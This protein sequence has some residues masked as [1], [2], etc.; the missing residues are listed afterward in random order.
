MR[1]RPPRTLR[2]RVALA[3]TVATVVVLGV[4]GVAFAATFASREHRDFNRE[5]ASRAERLAGPDGI[6]GRGRSGPGGD[7][8]HDLPSPREP[9]ERDLLGAEGVGVRVLAGSTIIYDNGVAPAALPV[10]TQAGSA[11]Y[12]VDGERYRSLARPLRGP[13]DG[14]GGAVQV[15]APLA[16]VDARISRV[17]RL[18]AAGIAL[19]AVITALATRAL[20]GVALRPLAALREGAARVSGTEDLTARLPHAGPDEVE[21]LAGSLNAMLGRLERSAAGTDAALQAARRFTADAGHELRT[22]LTSLHANIEVLFRNPGLPAGER[23]RVMRALGADQ[24]RLVAL[25][26]GLQSLA[27]GDAGAGT[28]THAVDLADLADAA[29]ASAAARH[30]GVAFSLSGDAVTVRGDEAGLR[31]VLDNLLENAARHGARHVEAGLDASDGVVRL[32]ID[33]DGPGVPDAERERVFERFAR[34][35]GTTVPG[36]GLGLAI[37]GQQAA[38]HGGRIT[39]ADAPTGGARFTVELPVD[40]GQPRPGT[41]T[42]DS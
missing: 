24:A 39:V 22:P 11:T 29:I 42:P 14:D 13:G 26:D 8:G 15:A 41:A 32:T 33:D 34:G 18:V 20:A 3:A 28:R 40:A 5:L 30:P 35:D 12:T 19:A 31:A 2:G 4:M 21:D 7:G 27:R 23:E 9:F 10:A 17:Q 25:L 37:A 1:L 16:P 38:L 36:S 6:R